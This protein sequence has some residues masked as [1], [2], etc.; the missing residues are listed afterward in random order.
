MA[1]AVVGIGHKDYIPETPGDFTAASQKIV[2]ELLAETI[3]QTTDLPLLV[4][5]Q[6][7]LLK[8]NLVRPNP[9]NPNAV[10]TDERVLM[11]LIQL[12]KDAGAAE[13]W[14]GDNPGYGL[15]L[16]QALEQMSEFKT[17]LAHLNV[18]LRFFDEEEK[19]T[20]DNP[21]AVIFDPVVLPVSLMEA[22]VYINVP[23]MK[24]HMHTL[25]TLGI[26]NQ[27]GLILDDQRMFYHRN[28]I[29]VKIVDILRVVKPHLTVI[30][31]IYAV[32]GQAPLSGSVVEHM[33]TI[34][35]GEDVVAVDTVSASLMGI[36]P[37][38]VAML[39]IARAE[40]LGV[41]DLDDI[42]I[43]GADPDAVRRP[44]KRPVVSPMG[45]YDE[46]HAIEGGACTGCL[47]ALRHSLD[48]LHSEGRLAGNLPQTVYI[49]KPMPDMKNV[50][51]CKG[52][53]WCFGSCTSDL[54]FNHQRC[55]EKARFIPGCPPHILEFYKAYLD[56]MADDNEDT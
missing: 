41:A 51:S 33:N 35:C 54:I 13:I 43:R 21:T 24:T 26:K 29:N 32:Q 56:A 27:Y 17:R 38:E 46:I 3:A 2:T 39:R 5:G 55:E 19:I 36:D 25:V 50:K 31:G 49:G 44:F 10:V 4:L 16:A 40:K 20:V 45:A 18:R 11:G 42:E 52:P 23:K 6:K 7:V 8:P 53:M 9:K 12:I 15:P 22:D 34:V 48:K 28:D 14:V 37:M 47:S 1:K 30:D